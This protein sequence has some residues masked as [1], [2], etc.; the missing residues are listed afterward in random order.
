MTFSTRTATVG[1]KSSWCVPVIF[2]TSLLGTHASA[3]KHSRHE[4]AAFLDANDQFAFDL[5][6][7]TR[8][9][10]QDR[11]IVVAPLPVSLTFAA[12]SY[13]T[14]YE[15]AKEF[16]AA[17][18]WQ[19]PFGINVPGRMLLARFAKPKPRPIPKLF[20]DI[21][22]QAEEVWLS[23]AFLY[24]G[25]GSLSQDFIDRVKYDF[26]FE[27]RAVDELGAQ[28]DILAKNWDPTLPMP[29]IKGEHDFWITS[30]THLRTFWAG[31]TFLNAKRHKGDFTLQSG[32][33][34]NAQFLKTEFT[35]YR[36]AQTETFEAVVLPGLQ[37][38]ILLVVPAG[39]LHFSAR[40]DER[41]CATRTCSGERPL[42]HRVS[43]DRTVGRPRN[44]SLPLFLRN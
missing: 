34:I 29:A 41:C 13:G 30:S 11:N 21:P 43:S 1:Q 19:E 12:L 14:D 26:A 36:H 6:M 38:S 42:P 2:F 3:Q 9:D 5:L 39:G 24:R 16:A 25:E 31:N 35:A 23:A 37:A 44:P 4:P 28:S 33:L 10:E 27:F 15:S 40:L 18:H 32:K 22:R 17:F 20:G 7:V 8:K